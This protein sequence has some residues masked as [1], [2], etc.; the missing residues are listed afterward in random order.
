MPPLPVTDAV[1]EKNIATTLGDVFRL[2]N[3]ADKVGTRAK[4]VYY[5]CAFLL[6]ASITEALVFDFIK[7]RTDADPSLIPRA[8][9]TTHKHIQHLNSANLDTPK[10]LSIV[11]EVPLAATFADITKDFNRMNDFCRKHL[12]IPPKQFRN[13]DY[14]RRKRNEIHLQ[15]LT[16]SSRSYTRVQINKVGDSMVDMLVELET[17]NPTLTVR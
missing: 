9:T 14:V 6:L 12:S 2:L 4:T 17:L 3:D 10:R 16:S 15:G 1:L 7:C 5:K 8:D 11:E 13:L